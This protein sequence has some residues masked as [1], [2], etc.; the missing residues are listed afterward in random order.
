L[1]SD[2]DDFSLSGLI[3]NISTTGCLGALDFFLS[4]FYVLFKSLRGDGAAL[5]SPNISVTLLSF[6]GCYSFLS[7]KISTT[8][9]DGLKLVLTLALGTSVFLLGCFKCSVAGLMKFVIR[10]LPD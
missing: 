5:L 3:P 8:L 10:F 2:D 6:L 4:K 1:F 7:T 9:A